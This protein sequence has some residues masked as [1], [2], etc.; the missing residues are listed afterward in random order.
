MTLNFHMFPFEEKQYAQEL[1]NMDPSM[2]SL[3][4]EKLVD[5]NIMSPLSG[6]PLET[7]ATTL[8]HQNF[9]SMSA[10]NNY[11]EH[12]MTPSTYGSFANQEEDGTRVSYFWLTQSG[13]PDREAAQKEG[14]T[15]HGRAQTKRPH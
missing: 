3:Q 8:G 4:Y 13:S 11:N 15:Q 6:S 5:D 2:L 12:I 7:F 14:V 1:G 10:P 9:F